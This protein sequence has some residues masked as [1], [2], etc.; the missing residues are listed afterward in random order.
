MGRGGDYNSATPDVAGLEVGTFAHLKNFR[1]VIKRE[2]ERSYRQWQEA[3][4]AG[5]AATAATCRKRWRWICAKQVYLDGEHYMITDKPCIENG[6]RQEFGSL[7]PDAK[8]RLTDEEIRWNREMIVADARLTI[9]SYGRGNDRRDDRD[10]SSSPDRDRSLSPISAMEANIYLFSDWREVAASAVAAAAADHV[11]TQ[12]AAPDPPHGE[13]PDEDAEGSPAAT[14]WLDLAG[15][16][17]GTPTYHLGPLCC[18]ATLKTRRASACKRCLRDD[19][20]P[21]FR[22]HR[23]PANRYHTNP[24]CPS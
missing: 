13:H 20:T 3:E 14:A 17:R 22:S 8:R 12:P 1:E 18:R 24:N 9:A 16:T 23:C 7:G 21:V 4:E 19:P 10:R 11:A 2:R 5:D 15:E 6:R